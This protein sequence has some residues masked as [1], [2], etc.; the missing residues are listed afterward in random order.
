MNPRMNWRLVTFLGNL[1]DGTYCIFVCMGLFEFEWF[2]YYRFQYDSCGIFR[3]PRHFYRS[4][5]QYTK[6]A[7]LL[8][9]VRKTCIKL[10]K[11]PNKSLSTLLSIKRKKWW[12]L[13]WRKLRTV[14]LN[15][16]F[17]GLKS[18]IVG[19][20]ISLKQSNMLHKRL[21]H[22]LGQKK[23]RK[24]RRN[25]NVMWLEQRSFTPSERRCTF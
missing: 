5:V 22:K 13:P 2:H 9:N 7:R 20:W 4:S 16:N 6:I 18:K 15:K 14:F 25:A 1:K 21:F 17:R 3:T 24:L 8:G 10:R 23:N 12:H 11:L 19:S